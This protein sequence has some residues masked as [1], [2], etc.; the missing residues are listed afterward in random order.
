MMT[1]KVNGE[2]MGVGEQSV[3]EKENEKN[4]RKVSKDLEE[5]KV[6]K[7]IL[8]KSTDNETSMKKVTYAEAVKSTMWK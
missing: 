4:K 7:S 5:K 3:T 2:C 8:R 6:L 1:L